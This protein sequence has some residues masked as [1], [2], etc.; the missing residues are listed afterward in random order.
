MALGKEVM[1]DFD[2]MYLGVKVDF[3][4]GVK[5]LGMADDRR[6]GGEVGIKDGLVLGVRDGTLLGRIVGVDEGERTPK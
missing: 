5:E 6:L 2:G 1:G 4:V 3:C